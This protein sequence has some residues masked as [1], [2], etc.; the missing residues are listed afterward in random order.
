MD[1]IRI[2]QVPTGPIQFVSFCMKPSILTVQMSG[3]SLGSSFQ[4][5]FARTKHTASLQSQHQ[6]LQSPECLLHQPDLW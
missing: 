3:S 1:I 6:L 4:F 5:S 2:I